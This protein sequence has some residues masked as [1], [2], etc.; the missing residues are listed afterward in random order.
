MLASRIFTHAYVPAKAP[1]PC[2]RV[3][4]MFHGL[5][6]SL[7]DLVWVTP[8]LGIDSLSYL[9]VNA[10]YDHSFGGFSWFDVPADGAPVGPAV[11][12]IKRSRELIQGLFGELKDQ[13]VAP[14]D[15]FL[16]GFSQGSMMALDAGLRFGERLGGIV[17]VS[18]WLGFQE[19]YLA[20]FSPIAKEQSFFLTHGWQDRQVPFRSVQVQCEF[21]A[22][23]GIHLEFKLYDKDHSI[24]PEEVQDIREWLGKRLT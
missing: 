3:M 4:V 12:S 9:L 6:Q 8:E 19:D 7:R 18:S 2:D 15:I 22:S 20:A 1:G 14:S 17:G 24:L 23:Q 21:L 11:E 5:G 16:F 13:G 10:P